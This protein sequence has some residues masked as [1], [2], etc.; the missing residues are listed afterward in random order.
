MEKKEKYYVCPYKFYAK[1]TKKEDV[2]SEKNILICESFIVEETFD[3]TQKMID[4]YG[5]KN[6]QYNGY[7]LSSII[8]AYKGRD[9]KE[10]II[11]TDHRELITVIPDY[12][13]AI[14]FCDYWGGGYCGV[15]K[16]GFANKIYDIVRKVKE[17]NFYTWS[18]EDGIRKINIPKG[19]KVNYFTNTPVPKTSTFFS[20]SSTIID[21]K[22]DQKKEEK[23]TSDN[24]ENDEV[25]ELEKSI[26][27]EVDNII[28]LCDSDTEKLDNFFNVLSGI[29]R[30]L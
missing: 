24:N 25:S 22:F 12:L 28:T 15:E 21:G 9:T 23:L 6:I 3:M 11:K 10:M 29:V 13:D 17:P 18:R 1:D 20:T 30:M 2:T 16:V 19:V 14:F 5:E 4:M 8:R 7:L 27:S 26:R